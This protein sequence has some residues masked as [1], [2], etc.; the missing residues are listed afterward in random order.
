MQMGGTSSG[1][2][3]MDFDFASQPGKPERLLALDINEDS[4]VII[5]M[6]GIIMMVSPGACS[7]LGYDRKELEAQNVAMLMPAPF[8]IRHNSYL[9][10]SVTGVLQA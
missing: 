8:N 6:Q 1:I 5:N 2:Q 10:V 9:Q 3:S 4:V 7:M